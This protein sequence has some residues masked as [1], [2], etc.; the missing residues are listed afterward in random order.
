MNRIDRGAFLK[1]SATLLAGGA[2]L[3]ACSDE[4]EDAARGAGGRGGAAGSSAAAGSGGAAAGST[5][6]GAGG[7]TGGSGGASGGTPGGC[8]KDASLTP[9]GAL[10]HDHLPLVRPIT[11]ML[12]NGVAFE[13]A[14]PNEQG[15]I[16]TIAFTEAHLASLRAGMTIAITSTSDGGHSHTYDVTCT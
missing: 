7:A 1:L 16:H 15:H 2:G 4:G 9:T 5:G 10:S 14:L 3:S 6:G 12:L 11:A 13:F 8:A